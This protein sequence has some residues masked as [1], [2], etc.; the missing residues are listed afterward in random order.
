VGGSNILSS[1]LQ[2]FVTKLLSVT[3]DSDADTIVCLAGYKRGVNAFLNLDS[4]L[5]SRFPRSYELGGYDGATLLSIM[6]HYLKSN[7]QQDVDLGDRDGFI[8]MLENIRPSLLY[9]DAEGWANARTAETIAENANT[10]NRNKSV[11]TLDDF[12]GV[13]LKIGS[14]TYVI[15]DIIDRGKDDPLETLKSIAGSE[16]LVAFLETIGNRYTA[17][18]SMPVK[19]NIALIMDDGLV[20]TEEVARCVAG[21][22]AKLWVISKPVFREFDYSA[23]RSSLVNRSSVLTAQ[24]F[25]KAEGCLL[26]FRNPGSVMR[27]GQ[28]DSFREQTREIEAR[29]KEASDPDSGMMMICFDTA[30]N[31]NRLKE[32]SR[33][34]TQ[35]FTEIKFSVNGAEN[36]SK[37]VFN[38]LR[39]MNVEYTGDFEKAL[40]RGLA[41]GKL[42]DID[43]AVDK[44][45]SEHPGTRKV[46]LDGKDASYFL[47][48]GSKQ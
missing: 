40:T 44:Y 37:V 15:G 41:N 22:M 39:R 24:Q 43:S 28:Y 32:E 5:K 38:S 19:R 30:E 4:G 9:E 17:G 46:T 35:L 6:R 23:T 14:S 29:A 7:Y 11:L 42:V 33:N 26:V 31:W 45:L 18:V 3:T 8:A 47:K 10:L 20:N 25:E 48:G 27:S 2:V 12:R 34:F 1:A 21:Y 13:E 16:G 36:L